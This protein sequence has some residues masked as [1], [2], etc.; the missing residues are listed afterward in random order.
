[1]SHILS[2]FSFSFPTTDVDDSHVM[3]FALIL[4][5]LLDS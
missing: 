5:E 2:S 1:M 3:F 4:V